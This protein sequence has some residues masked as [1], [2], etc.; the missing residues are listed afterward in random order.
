[1]KHLGGGPDDM[2]RC[3]EF[4]LEK[5]YLNNISLFGYP[6]VILSEIDVFFLGRIVS[7]CPNS[8]PQF[9]ANKSR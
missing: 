5:Q 1:M 2:R 9:P 8:A 6:L 3:Y 7:P 4:L